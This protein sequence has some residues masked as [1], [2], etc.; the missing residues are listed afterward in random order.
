M[1]VEKKHYDIFER[2]RSTV[3]GNIPMEDITIASPYA[4]LQFTQSFAF[5]RKQL[6]KELQRKF[7]LHKHV[8]TILFNFF[9]LDD[10]VRELY[11]KQGQKIV[12]KT[13]Q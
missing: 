9:K 12:K 11:L 6:S 1:Q 5:S 4:I 10:R 3:F 13:T 8:F 7:K 2:I